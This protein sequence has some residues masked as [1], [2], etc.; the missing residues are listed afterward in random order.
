MAHRVQP[1]YIQTVR[2]VTASRLVDTD[3]ING[4]GKTLYVNIEVVLHIT[5]TPASL[6]F[7]PVVD[8]ADTGLWGVD[9]CT[10]SM[11]MFGTVIIF[12]KPGSTY[13]LNKWEVA[14]GTIRFQNWIESY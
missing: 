11:D 3:Y 12:V 7:I 1:A 2:N 13:R 14:G 5:S 10:A 9:A 8:G 4:T 6:F